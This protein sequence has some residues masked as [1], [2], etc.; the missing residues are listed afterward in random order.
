MKYASVLSALAG[1][2]LALPQGVTEL[3][4]PTASSPDGC[5]QSYSGSFSITIL[6]ATTS[7][8]LSKRGLAA[9]Q[10]SGG[11]ADTT[12]VATLADGQLTDQKGRTGYI[13]SNFQLQF[14]DPPQAGAIYT[15]GFSACSNSSI[16]LG[17]STVFYACPS[18]EGAT[19]FYNFYDRSWASTCSAI[20]INIIPGN[21]EGVPARSDGQPVATEVP[22][23]SDGQPIASAVPVRSDGQP[24]AS[25]V[26]V[27]SDGQ[28]IAS[29]YPAPVRSDGQPIATP[30]PIRSDGQPIASAYPAPVPIRSD[31]QPIAVNTPTPVSIR[32]DGQPIATGA[33][34]NNL[35][36]PA[37]TT[38]PT[39]PAAFTGGAQRFN[40]GSGVAFV[41]AAAVA[42]AML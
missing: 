14:D 7:A 19:K 6:N 15:G 20:Y 35:T 39:A 36:A 21:G 1:A 37:A 29:A 8:G 13:A 3:I 5:D 34:S 30:V 33:A 2:A 41:G 11:P 24:I 9:R 22:V 27:R 32:T 26:P 17:G 25:A 10:E 4:K 40:V 18:G 16:A 23:R 38:P 12:L 28:P 42:V 31:G